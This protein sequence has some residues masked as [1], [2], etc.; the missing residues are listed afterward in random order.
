[1]PAGRSRY[2]GSG[3]GVAPLSFFAYIANLAL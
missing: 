2:G 1:M 3:G